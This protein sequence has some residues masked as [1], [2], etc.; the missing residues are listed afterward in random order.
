MIMTFFNKKTKIS[1]EKRI[2]KQ[3]KKTKK[4]PRQYTKTYISEKNCF[5]NSKYKGC[6]TLG[7]E[8]IR[9]YTYRKVAL[10]S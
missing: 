4:T 3:Q 5:L 8:T 9:V 1:V 2:L 7:R 10:L 6:A